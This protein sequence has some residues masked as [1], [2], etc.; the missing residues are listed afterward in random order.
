MSNRNFFLIFLTKFWNGKRR[1]QFHGR[2]FKKNDGK[3]NLNSNKNRAKKIQQECE[4]NLIKKPNEEED[5]EELLSI[6][7]E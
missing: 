5:G 2:K 4:E 6:V 1:G 3:V 7:K